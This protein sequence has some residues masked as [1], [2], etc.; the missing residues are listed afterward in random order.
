VNRVQEPFSRNAAP[1]EARGR[2]AHDHTI[3]VVDIG[4]NS[5]RL[6]AYEGLT[7]APTPVFNEKV[8]AGLGRGVAT[9]GLLPADGV[10][11]AYGAL[12]RFR[13]LID[14]MGIRDVR[15][16]ATAAARDARN[17]AEFLANAEA[18]IGAPIELIS[19]TREAH[20]SA[21]GVISG[22]HR[23]D[24]FVGDLGGGSLELVE[25]SGTRI[26][27]GTS[28]KLGGLALQDAA[29]GSLKKAV[30]IVR[31]TL[32]DI[33]LPY[34][35][36]NFYA[37]GG[38]WRSLSKLHMSHVS[39]PLNV[40]HAYA[41]E[42]REAI[43]FCR[44]VQRV[45]PESLPAIES[46][47]ASRRPLLAYGA[48]ALEYVLR[49]S[50]AG[51]VIFSAQGVRE[52]L[53]FELLDHTT[54]EAD[55]LLSAA[56]ELNQLRS[57][58]PRHGEELALWADAFLGTTGQTETPDDRRLRH[59]S[60]LLADIGWRAHPDY[61]GEQSLNIIAHANVGGVTHAGRLFIALAVATR[62][63]GLSD[64]AM[65]PRLRDLLTPRDLERARMLGA[66]MR[67][68]YIISAA[69]P[70]VLPRAPLR[71]EGARLVLALP[72]DLA[73]LDSDRLSTRMK[74]LAR[75]VGKEPVVVV[76]T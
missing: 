35:G 11:Q 75:L 41:V 21:L 74:Q 16:L 27:A 56:A 23:P 48:L 33:D 6:V 64:S 67:V 37:V 71:V 73:D 26:G 59:A 5:V 15:V 14:L 39:Y 2:F 76:E 19:G 31:D 49:Q 54:R 69:M 28:V 52:G 34:R 9:T 13:K 60:C 29:G 46:V 30:R 20:L 40:T 17:G 66:I 32:D 53:L 51:R 61:R 38:T 68:A 25:V 45:V 58:S 36:R 70:G 63:V 3:A 12:R 4:S 7:R 43:E 44:L 42:A 10:K 24:G 18:M 55:P 47:S 1:L 50:E 72:G 22:F 57:R 8:L 65:T 62:H